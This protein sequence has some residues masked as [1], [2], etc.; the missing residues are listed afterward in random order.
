[1]NN[2]QLKSFVGSLSCGEKIDIDKTVSMRI[3][4]SY[5]FQGMS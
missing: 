2:F 1:M 5:R 4:R 3:N